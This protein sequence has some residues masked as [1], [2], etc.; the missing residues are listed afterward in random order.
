MSDFRAKGLKGK[1]LASVLQE[2]QEPLLDE[3]GDTPEEDDLEAAQHEV[4]W[5]RKEV[6]DLRERVFLG[7]EEPVD[8]PLAK[9]ENDPWSRIAAVVAAAIV[10]AQIVGQL[11]LSTRGT[12]EIATKGERRL[13][14]R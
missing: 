4:A 6:A 12:A 13:Q 2:I 3:A 10:F 9:V 8:V 7:L 1:E 11:R 14:Q 5:L